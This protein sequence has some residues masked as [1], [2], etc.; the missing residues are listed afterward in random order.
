[1][2]KDIIGEYTNSL[3]RTYPNKFIKTCYEEPGNTNSNAAAYY[4]IDVSGMTINRYDGITVDL[5]TVG[6]ET[7]KTLFIEDINSVSDGYV[8]ID[9]SESI[10]IF[11][12]DT[13]SVLTYGLN[14]YTDT[15]FM[16]ICLSISRNSVTDS[17]PIIEN[18]LKSNNRR[19]GEALHQGLANLYISHAIGFKSNKY[20]VK[21]FYEVLSGISLKHHSGFLTNILDKLN[22][23]YDYGEE[24]Y[25]SNPR[26]KLEY[27]HNYKSMKL[28]MEYPR[29]VDMGNLNYEVRFIKSESEE[30]VTYP[31]PFENGYYKEIVYIDYTTP[32]I[33]EDGIFDVYI[34]MTSDSPYVK[35]NPERN[36]SAISIDARKKIKFAK[37]SHG[38]YLEN[39]NASSII[40]MQVEVNNVY[41]VDFLVEYTRASTGLPDTYLIKDLYNQYTE[42][43]KYMMNG[44][45]PSDLTRDI[46]N[47]A[48]MKVTAIDSKTGVHHD[49]ITIDKIPSEYYE[50]DS[51]QYGYGRAYVVSYR[52]VN[53]SIVIE[54][55]GIKRYTSATVEIIDS[56]GVVVDTTTTAIS[57]NGGYIQKYAYLIPPSVVDGS[58][59]VRITG[60]DFLE[61]IFHSRSYIE[62]DRSKLDQPMPYYDGGTLYVSLNNSSF[63]QVPFN[64][65]MYD[66]SSNTILN[67]F[68]INY[69][70]SMSINLGVLD[71]SVG[72]MYSDIF[73]N[74]PIYLSCT[75]FPMDSSVITIPGDGPV[76]YILASYDD[77][78]TTFTFT[79]TLSRNV[80]ITYKMRIADNSMDKVGNFTIP[81]NGGTYDLPI[82]KERFVGEYGSMY[83][84]YLYLSDNN[85]RVIDVIDGYFDFQDLGE[86]ILPDAVDIA[87]VKSGIQIYGNSIIGYEYPTIEEGDN[88]N[89]KL[90]NS[91]TKKV[92]R[93][94]T[95]YGINKNDITGDSLYFLEHIPMYLMEEDRFIVEVYKGSTL[96]DTKEV[97]GFMD[98][99]GGLVSREYIQSFYNGDYRN[100]TI[101]YSDNELDVFRIRRD[102]VEDL[103][104]SS[105]YF[106]DKRNAFSMNI[107]L[108]SMNGGVIA[109]NMPTDMFQFNLGS[110]RSIFY[111]ITDSKIK[112]L[113]NL[114]DSRVVFE[115]D[116]SLPIGEYFQL[117]MT[118]NED[119]LS[120]YVN[121]DLIFNKSDD[122]STD[123]GGSLSI[124]GL[125]LL[126]DRG[127]QQIIDTFPS[128]ADY[129]NSYMADMSIYS[130][131]ARVSMSNI[132]DINKFLKENIDRT[133]PSSVLGVN[134]LKDMKC[135]KAIAIDT[136]GNISVSAMSYRAHI[137]GINGINEGVQGANSVM[138]TYDSND[139]SYGKNIEAEI[140]LDGKQTDTSSGITLF[141]SSMDKYSLYGSECM[142]YDTTDIMHT[143]IS[144]VSNDLIGDL[145]IVLGK[146]VDVDD[147]LLSQGTISEKQSILDAVGSECK[148]ITVGKGSKL[149]INSSG[150]VKKISIR[151]GIVYFNNIQVCDISSILT[152][153]KHVYPIIFG[154]TDI[155]I[156]SYNISIGE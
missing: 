120:F 151:D 115:E 85:A 80:D 62:V 18:L 142:E 53:A 23:T 22:S 107:K 150:Y 126:Y 112:Y 97:H 108:D 114:F 113:A 29:F 59:S 156:A 1:M 49:T 155:N 152:S 41:S 105:I 44:M 65:D 52:D 68:R 55:Y 45:F 48:G 89:A 42:G 127:S 128:F 21:E 81:G 86:K 15:N 38:E 57:N 143:A 133:Q 60:I 130:Y 96:V 94:F 19:N 20:P 64:I 75:K 39:D 43:N 32:Y 54:G 135:P 30:V 122:G 129:A 90:I 69:T 92:E 123:I 12:A 117:S 25:Y 116:I 144:I 63:L 95:Q 13:D 2:I 74:K 87:V 76:R 98:S 137:N 109:T 153:D 154:Y 146:D 51:G 67:T 124:G 139:T 50:Y 78:N 47:S 28:K 56:N 27:I 14:N 61:N 36:I 24:S 103:G 6:I 100:S 88:Y 119:G 7:N 73:K 148:I 82:D 145:Q 33:D 58:Y 46:E 40:T 10:S 8:T 104:V 17:N 140:I 16:N 77:S 99:I 110:E 3:R 72:Y 134:K 131:F 66:L 9:S 106:S 141:S 91:E 37:Y 125:R 34:K 71:I 149:P 147:R 79:N 70:S 4:P 93:V 136:D 35:F 31:I 132:S 138:I 84:E 26:Y 111:A 102:A 121:D 11:E 118:F 101:P 83:V 5:D